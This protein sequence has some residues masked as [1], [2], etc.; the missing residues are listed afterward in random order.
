M[1]DSKSFHF[2]IKEVNILYLQVEASSIEEA[3]KEFRYHLKD[4]NSMRDRDLDD[5]SYFEVLEAKPF[6]VLEIEEGTI[7]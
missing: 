3:R 6:A 4:A 7:V 2:K 5:N 1:T